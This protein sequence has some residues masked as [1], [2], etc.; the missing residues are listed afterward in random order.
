MSLQSAEEDQVMATRILGPAGG[1]RRRR[2]LLFLPLAAIA[3]LVFALTASGG[4]IST[5]SGFEGDDGNLAPSTATDWNSF[6][7][8]NYLPSPSTTPTRQADKVVSG[9]TF[10]GLEDWQATTSDNGFAG[11]VKQDLNCA[12][13]KGTK[14]PNKD[15]LKRIYVS[16][17]TDS[18]GNVFLE[19]AWVRIP[20]NTTSASAHV[21]FEFNQGTTPCHSPSNPGGLVQ[22]TA[23]DMLI[24]YDFA[25]STT[26]NPILTVRRWVT[27]PGSTCEISSDSAPCWGPAANLTAS[28]FAEAKVNTTSTALDKLTPPAL[29]STTGTSV[30]STLGLNEFGE[31]V[32]NLTAAGIFSAQTCT[33]FGQVEGVSRSSGNSGQAA[34]EDLV[35]PGLISISNCGHLVVKK[36]TDPSPDPTDTSFSYDEDG[37][38]N[39]TTMPRTFSLKNGETD[40][41][42]VFPATDFSVAET[43]PS[44]WTLTS[45]SCDHST[46]TTDL[47]AGTITDIAVA[48]DETVTCTFTNTLN[49]GALR[50]LK[51]STKSGNPLVANDG[52]VFSYDGSSVTDNGTGDES[53]TVGEVCVSGLAPGDYTV[54][55]TT[56][57]SGYGQASETDVTATVVNGT[58]CTDNLPTDANT[59]VFTDPPLSDIQVNFRDGGSGET[60]A[61]I[62][63]DNTTGS[64]PD[65]TPATGWDTSAT[66][67]GIN[68]PTTVNCT[69]T[70]DP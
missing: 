46:G 56:P 63:C 16:H 37:S 65:T 5:A 66:I 25:G 32:I 41:Q 11:G 51:E 20:Q 13:V 30:D 29:T 12:T 59:A 61:T 1:R 49:Q 17:N 14:A 55:E 52:A 43:V 36:V 42:Q 70:I 23:G 21:G 8:V 24:V 58:N 26:D 38:N 35:G 53:S 2:L 6:A 44:S 64:T 68:A 18:S 22:R 27:T 50:I 69:I 31:A 67:T 62:S 15:D 33:S 60:S 9:F 4:P 48:V 54:N 40:S 47:G 19:L 10:K 34:M 28:G 45:A 39:S 3:A 7:P 57:P